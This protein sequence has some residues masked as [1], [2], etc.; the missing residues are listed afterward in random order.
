MDRVID[1]TVHHGLVKIGQSKTATAAAT[2]RLSALALLGNHRH[3]QAHQG[4]NVSGQRA[5]GARHHH[6]VVFGGQTG[7]DLHNARVFGAGQLFDFA[8]QFDFGRAVH[9]AHGVHGRVERSAGRHFAGR[10]FD[11]PVLRRAANAA[12]GQGRVHQ[13]GQGNIV[14]ISKGGFL[15]RHSAHTHALVDAETAGFDNALFQAP[16][17]RAGVLKVQIRIVNLVRFDGRQGLRQMRFV[18]TK[19]FK[20]EGPGR[21]QAFESGFARDHGPIVEKDPALRRA[22]QRSTCARAGFSG[23]AAST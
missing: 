3:R 17:F 4:P 21:G 12:Y 14:G 16:A 22:S 18:Q 15:A 6:H 10:H 5:V 19:R 2:A 9:A 13:G 11:A 20:Q 1:V 23:A 7:H 8:Q